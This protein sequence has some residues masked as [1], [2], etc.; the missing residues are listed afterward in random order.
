MPRNEPSASNTS[1]QLSV[2]CDDD[3]KQQYKKAL[4]DTAMSDD[5]R[6]H[7]ERVVAEHGG[8]VTDTGGLPENDELRTAYRRLD[9]LAWPDDHRVDVETAISDLASVLNRPKKTI[10]RAVI[11][12]LAHR[13]YVSPE[14][15][16][17]A[18]TPI[19]QLAATDGGQTDE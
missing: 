12:P 19:E 17:L 11:E 8:R 16:V 9:T 15:G 5:L 18:V 4:G 6:E 2:R 14:W 1:A 3:L 10:R 13:G 7:M